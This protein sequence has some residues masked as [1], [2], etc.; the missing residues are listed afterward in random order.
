MGH[1]LSLTYLKLQKVIQ[2]FGSA[3]FFMIQ[4]RHGPDQKFESLFAAL[5]SQ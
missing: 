2:I 4:M 1:G 3:F 5:V